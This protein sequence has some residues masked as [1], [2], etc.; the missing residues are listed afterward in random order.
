M[1]LKNDRTE[2]EELRPALPPMP[3][4]RF[5]VVRLEERVAPRRGGKPTH[6]GCGQT[7]GGGGTYY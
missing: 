2:S 6:H 4:R 5:R 7:T 1:N 3:R